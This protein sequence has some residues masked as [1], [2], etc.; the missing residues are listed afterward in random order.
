MVSD[1]VLAAEVDGSTLAAAIVD[2]DGAILARAAETVEQAA[3]PKIVAQLGRVARQLA[4]KSAFRAAA[5]AVNGAV[6]RDGMIPAPANGQSF[7]IGEKLRQELRLPVTVTSDRVAAV[8]GESWKGAADD[9]DTVVFVVGETIRAG[10][11]IGGRMLEGAHGLAGAAGWMAVSEADG[12]EVRKFGGLE[13]F[14]SAPGIVRAARNAIEAGFGGSLAEYDP[15]LFT[16]EDIAELARRG[17]VTARQ[18]YRRAGKQLGLAVANLVSLFDPEFLIV[19]GSMTAASDLFWPDLLEIAT[20]RSR[21][22][23]AR[24]VRICLSELRGDA[25]LLGAAKAAWGA[26]PAKAASRKSPPRKSRAASR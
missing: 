2:R 13:A 11:R 6:S 5:I 7:P 1:K 19:A 12:F 22:D 10:V 14:A 25:V 20:L 8:T 16:A 3:L 17:D 26:M 4:K 24:T 21:P 18:I 15:N 9:K 23:S